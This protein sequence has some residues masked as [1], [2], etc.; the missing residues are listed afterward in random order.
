MFVSAAETKN[1]SFL[2]QNRSG[3][4]LVYVMAVSTIV[5]VFIALSLNFLTVNLKSREQLLKKTLINT[6]IQN[7]RNQLYDGTICPQVL[8]NGLNTVTIGPNA[9]TNIQLQYAMQGGSSNTITT[10]WTFENNIQLARLELRVIN[11]ALTLK[12]GI[13]VRRGNAFGPAVPYFPVRLSQSPTWPLP[14]A[15][16]ASSLTLDKYLAEIRVVPDGIPFN[17]TDEKNVIRLY[18]K[19]S[20]AG[21]IVQCHGEVS[22]A[23]SCEA[24]GMSYDGIYAPVNFRCNPDFYCRKDIQL[25]SPTPVCTPPYRAQLLSY[26]ASSGNRLVQCAWCNP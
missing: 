8:G 11:P 21:Q 13:V 5:S 16:G 26:E 1:N 24:R 10:G 15:I 9:I 20:P 14:W 12:N 19:V 7:L 17:F 6:V 3:F 23:E 2:I 22:E 4:A 18:I 25:I